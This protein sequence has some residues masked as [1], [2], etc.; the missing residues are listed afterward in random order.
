MAAAAAAGVA[1]AAM[2]NVIRNK[3]MQES[4]PCFIDWM[5]KDRYVGF[6]LCL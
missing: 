2:G 1:Q 5:E 3:G 4:K 6:L